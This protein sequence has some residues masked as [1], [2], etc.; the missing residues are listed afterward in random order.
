M[1]T[2]V[3]P[4]KNRAYI[5]K[6]TIPS[7]FNQ[8]KISEIIFVND[9]SS[10]NTEQVLKKFVSNKNNQKVKLINNKSNLGAS[11]SRNI[12]AKASRNKF[13]LFCD[14]DEI[15]EKGYGATLLT[16]LKKLNASAISG[17]RIYLLTG[18]NPK[19]AR[20][21][22]GNGLRK[23]SFFNPLLLEYSNGATF[24]SDLCVPFTNANILT[25]KIFVLK[26][27]FDPYYSKGNGYREETDFQLNL[28]VNGHNIFITNDTHTFHLPY[29]Q[30]KK[31]GQRI[32]IIK[33]IF[34]SNYFNCYFLKKYYKKYLI[35]SGSKVP[36]IFVIVF[37]FLFSIY[38]ETL[39]PILYSGLIKIRYFRFYNDSTVTERTTSASG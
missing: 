10:D 21:R 20:Q 34:W 28:F 39:R 32:Q 35:R 6:K 19:Q 36:K 18:E 8:P 9:N 30:V 22:F 25:K 16:K 13:I 3:V 23:T 2:L 29:T 37:F 17:R 33:K 12:G 5:L 26:Y 31:G 7:F 38:R 1:I 14:D 11:A 15:M 27:K 24:T 4:T